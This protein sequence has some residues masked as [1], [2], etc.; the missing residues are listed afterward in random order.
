MSNNKYLHLSLN[1]MLLIIGFFALNISMYANGLPVQSTGFHPFP[2]NKATNVNPDTH[3]KL[4]FKNKPVLGDSGKIR[5]YDAADNSLV[6]SLD[7]SIPPGPTE[8]NRIK[9]PYT[10]TPYPYISG[11]FT[12]ANTKPGTPSGEALPTPDNYQLTI[13]GGFTDAF[14]FY[15]VIIHDTVATLYLHHNLLDYN[16]TYY[17]MIDPGVLT[18]ND[19]SFTGIT[20]QDEWTFSTKASPPELSKK[21]FEVSE[22]GDGDFNTVQ[23]AIDFIPDHHPERTIIF[24]KNGSYEE[25]VYFRNKG[26]VTFLGEDREKVVVCYANNEVFNPH[27][28]NIATNEWPG[29]FPSRRAAFMADNSNGIHLVNFTIRSINEKPAQAEGLLMMGEQNIVSN[30]T[31]EGSGDAL[32]IN[33][34]VYLSNSSIKGFGDNVLG[35]GPAFFKNCELISLY[36]PHVW[37]RNTSANHGNVF[38]DCS[39]KMEGN[40]STHI[41][42]TTDNNGKGYPYCEAVLLNCALDGIDPEGWSVKGEHTSNIHYWEYNSSNLS[43]GAPVDANKRHPLSRQLNK[44]TDSAIIAQYSDPAFVLGGWS[45]EMAPLILQQPK[46]QQVVKG[47]SIAFQINVAAVPMANFQWYKDGQPIE[48]A[49]GSALTIT[50]VSHTDEGQYYVYVENSSG[51]ATSKK[52]TL[53]IK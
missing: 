48:G 4:V 22:N 27:P 11:K 51:S 39:F 38:L 36:G 12:N 23:G 7:L 3:L 43:D 46:S 53:K 20:K 9:A 41:A 29:T 45:P 18:L 21:I 49:K 47:K 50:S 35:R 31:I 2:Q 6:D 16:K 37:I 28:V 15:P 32:Q 42:R 26:N 40:H 14:H 17:V 10:P 52:I 25:I 8:P 19:K 44:E 1:L 13:I 33:G 24:I 5:V 34:P 30:V